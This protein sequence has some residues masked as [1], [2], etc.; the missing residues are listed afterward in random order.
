MAHVV[1]NTHA[2]GVH[3]LDVVVHNRPTT[4]LNFQDQILMPSSIHIYV[5]T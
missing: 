2:Q 4:T 3:S 5:E 1:G